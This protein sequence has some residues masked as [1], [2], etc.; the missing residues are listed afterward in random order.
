MRKFKYTLIILSF[1]WWV[2]NNKPDEYVKIE[3][4][5]KNIK[6]PFTIILDIIDSLLYYKSHI[7]VLKVLIKYHL[8]KEDRDVMERARELAQWSFGYTRFL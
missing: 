2:K 7:R 3:N 1:L 6:L 5:F 4:N 8:E